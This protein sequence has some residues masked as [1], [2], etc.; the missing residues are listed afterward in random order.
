MKSTDLT[1]LPE[2][3]ENPFISELPP[4]LPQEDILNDL[5]VRPEF[6]DQE[7]AYPTHIR[8]HCIMRLSRYFE[9]MDRQIQLAERFDMLLR[10]GY[11]G[12]NPLTHDYVRY[13]QNGAERIE[14]TSLQISTHIPVENTAASFALAGCSGIGKSKA[15]ERVL[16][17]YPQCIQH[18]YPF[19]LVQ[20]PWLKLDC[21]HQGSPKQLC[22]NFFSEVDRLVGSSYFKWYGKRQSLDE[23]MVHMAQIANLHAIGVLVIDEIQHL[24]K[25]KIGSDSLLNFLVTLVNT[26]GVPVILIGTLSAVSLLQDNFRQ[27]RR[28][29]GLGSL[30]WDRMPAGKAWNYFIDQM[31]GYQWTREVTPITPEIR[32]ALYNESQGILALVVKLFMLAQMRVISIGAVRGNP[33]VLTAKLLSKVAKEDF[34][35][36][37]PM[38]VALRTN[39]VKALQKYDDLLPLQAHIDQI[40][41]SAFQAPASKLGR[42]LTIN[43]GASELK[44]SHD[45]SENIFTAL[46]AVGVADD[47]AGELVHDAR[48]ENPSEDP[49][50]LMATVIEMLSDKPVK[51]RK[52]KLTTQ[53]KPV[54]LPKQ[55]LRLIVEEGQKKGTPRYETLL[56]AKMV[57]PPLLDF[58]T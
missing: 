16:H 34:Q 51:R 32:E 28:A 29:S 15:M 56:A 14:A 9:P 55:D 2:Y 52:S 47:V 39:D 53:K 41:A 33:E 13:L 12:R 57:K 21:P 26:I 30:V 5:A 22:I 44:R 20:I 46:R 49:L 25:A 1:S 19:N 48:Q 50:T 18:T 42:Y 43:D 54:I 6:S 24:R 31:W 35:I 23:M 3:D 38:L 7:R 45:N 27:A 4:I 8:K 10:Q 58:A 40:V 17:Q 36:V 37:Q 11:V